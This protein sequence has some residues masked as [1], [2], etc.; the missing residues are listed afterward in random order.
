M[1]HESAGS[2]HKGLEQV[3]T[4]LS[5]SGDLD[6][7]THDRSDPAPRAMGS[8]MERTWFAF[9]RQ[10]TGEGN[11]TAEELLSTLARQ[12]SFQI[13]EELRFELSQRSFASEGEQEELVDDA[14]LSGDV[15]SM[16]DDDQPGGALSDDLPRKRTRSSSETAALDNMP[17]PSRT[18]DRQR[19]AVVYR[20]EGG[21][22]DEEDHGEDQDQVAGQPQEMSVFF[23]SQP[24]G[25]IAG[26]VD[27]SNQRSPSKD[28]KMRKVINVRYIPFCLHLTFSILPCVIST[29]FQSHLDRRTCCHHPLPVVSRD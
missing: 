10:T 6:I 3:T 11:D 1:P 26:P 14:S 28:G 27:C 13:D 15:H 12:G 16:M 24:A 4:P 19:A 20:D 5:L 7:N 2:S 9:N 21:V 22:E 25:Q 17:G 29:E 23:S 8:G 18:V